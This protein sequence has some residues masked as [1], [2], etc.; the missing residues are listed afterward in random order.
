MTSSS[1][2]RASQPKT[3]ALETV[4]PAAPALLQ[5]FAETAEAVAA[6]SGK[7][8]KT[9]LLG[10]YL[11]HLQDADLA[12]AARYFAGHQFALGG[13]GAALGLGSFLA[14]GFE[15]TAA[16]RAERRRVISLRPRRC[17]WGNRM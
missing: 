4:T 7:L 3:P 6:T 8:A 9:A 11:Q 10:E 16:I 15:F 14:D 13:F 12:R 1:N 5:T 2:K 17:R